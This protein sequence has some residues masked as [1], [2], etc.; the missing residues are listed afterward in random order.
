M[1]SG[2]R[3]LTASGLAALGAIVITAQAA[4]AAALGLPKFGKSKEPA[5]QQAADIDEVLK[6]IDRAIDE[7]R[8]LDAQQ[9]V[10]AVFL[11]G[12]QDKRLLLRVGELN[13]AKRRYPEAVRSFTDAEAVAGQRARALQ[14]KGVAYAEMGRGD[15]AVTALKAAVAEDPS[16]WRAWNGLAVEADR[17]HDFAEAETNYAAA[18]KAPGV[19]PVVLNN[20]GYSRLLQG[21]YADAS[22][23]FVR[24]LEIDPG[25]SEART[26]LR[27]SLAMQGRYDQ[28]TQVS[29]VED[30]G[31]VL[32]NAGFAAV[33][34]GDYPAAEKLFQQAVDAR[35]NAYGRALEN[36][37]MVKALNA[38]G[39][40]SQL[41]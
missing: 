31:T 25:L 37:K 36:L 28:A 18:L 14:G 21:R 39:G 2:A 4:P 13:L 10:D 29:G 11:R 9:Y 6:E 7:D 24:A 5:A 20:R 19:K 41:Q 38:Q 22:A 32:N 12:V 1:R 34:R 16:L 27:L 30:R 35:G 15:D 3:R 8:L 33:L 17:R 23:D 26:N 40:S